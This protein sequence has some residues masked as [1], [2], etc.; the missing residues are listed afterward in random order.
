ML[1]LVEAAKATQ[2]VLFHSVDRA[3]TLIDFLYQDENGAFHAFQA[4]IAKTHRADPGS[5]KTLVDSVQG[6]DQSKKVS[7]YYLVPG[8]LYKT[9]VTNPVDPLKQLQNVKSCEIWHVLVPNPSRSQHNRFARGLQEFRNVWG[10][11]VS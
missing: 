8:N 11:V 2:K 9:F 10:R 1:D 5:I 7:L 6:G 3:N 4:T